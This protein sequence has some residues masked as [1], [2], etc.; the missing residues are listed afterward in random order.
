MTNLTEMIAEFRSLDSQIET[1]KSAPQWYGNYEP[2]PKITLTLR[3]QE[4]AFAIARSLAAQPARSSVAI[5][6]PTASTRTR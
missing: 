5:V 4:L 2:V 3:R 1:T 6:T